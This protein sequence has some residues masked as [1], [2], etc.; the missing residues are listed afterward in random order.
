MLYTTN[1]RRE[2]LENWVVIDSWDKLINGDGNKK[3]KHQGRKKKPKEIHHAERR[4]V[5]KERKKAADVHPGLKKK[6]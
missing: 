4:N 2:R 3:K 6:T 5:K 1:G